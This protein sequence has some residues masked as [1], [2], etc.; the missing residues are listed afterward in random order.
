MGII[1]GLILRSRKFRVSDIHQEKFDDD[2][3]E[4][5]FQI[6]TLHQGVENAFWL[7]LAE[8]RVWEYIGCSSLDVFD[9]I[10]LSEGIPELRSDI[11]ILEV[12]VFAWVGLIASD[13]ASWEETTFR[14]Y[15]SESDVGDGDA[16]LS[17]ASLVERVKHAA[18]T[19]ASSWLLLL[20]R[21]DVDSPPDW[22]GDID[23][24]VGNVP[25]FTR[26]GISWVSFDVNCFQGSGEFDISEHDVS[27]TGM[28]G[29]GRNRADAHSDTQ[30]DVR[31][32][33]EDVLGA[34]DTFTFMT[35]FWNNSIIIIR[36]I[37]ISEGSVSSSHID[38]ISVQREPRHWELKSVSE[39]GW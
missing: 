39:D 17:W 38:S 7:F 28:L 20:L 23:V 22:V 27:H 34:V 6:V 36:N 16:W 32:L 3:F 21:T 35:W 29:V 2:G 5:A 1:H 18:W 31:V 19:G 15:I 25:D 30:V 4:T 26:A 10:A 13:D 24:F 8:S 37:Y 9:D 33:N 12:K 14:C 11:N